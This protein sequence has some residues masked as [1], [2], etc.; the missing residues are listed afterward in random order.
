MGM[1]KG[2][3]N[4]SFRS[5]TL[6]IAGAIAGVLGLQNLWGFGFF[7]V[8]VAFVNVMLIAVNTSYKPEQYFVIVPPP[9][10]TTALERLVPSK[11][12]Q[13]RKPQSLIRRAV[14]L[15]Q[16][17]LFQ[18]AQENILSFMLWWTL[19]FGLV[20]GMCVFAYGSV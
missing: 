10:L 20:H 11:A 19:W 18:G 6:S 4:G 14:F 7:L 3:Y 12:E 5:L 2:A 15:G 9:V 17:V 16:W 8:S 1:F 13:L